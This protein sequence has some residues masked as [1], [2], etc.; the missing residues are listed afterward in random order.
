MN[1]KK[2]LFPGKTLL[3]IKDDPFSYS[4]QNWKLF[5]EKNCETLITFDA[6]GE[7][8]KFGKDSMNKL[9]L[10][11]VKK[12]LPKRIFLLGGMDDLDLEPLE[13]IKT[14]FPEITLFTYF[15]DDDKLFDNYSK[16][17]ILFVDI[18]LIGQK[19]FLKRYKNEGIKNAFH[20]TGVNTQF[21]TPKKLKKK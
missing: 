17:M 9:F 18:G 12:T 21:F 3:L 15:G 1:N 4:Y 20:L 11:L 2:L 6:A 19:S 14:S 5:L 10:D 16:Y 7:C 13:E 8:K